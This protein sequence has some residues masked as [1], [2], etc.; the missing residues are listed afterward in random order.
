MSAV[1]ITYSSGTPY[2]GYFE[3]RTQLNVTFVTIPD[4]ITGSFKLRLRLGYS[5]DEN[6][7]SLNTFSD[8]RTA[9]YGA[10]FSEVL[11]PHIGERETS[12]CLCDGDGNVSVIGISNGL[13]SEKGDI[14]M[15]YVGF[16]PTALIGY[17]GGVLIF[18]KSKIV[19]E[20]MAG[21]SVG[22]IS[23]ETSVIKSDLGCDM[24]WSAVG[25]D[26]RIFFGNTE[27]GIFYLNKFG[28]SEKDGSCI[29][30]NAINDEL[31]SHTKSELENAVSVCTAGAYY[32]AVGDDVY[33]WHYDE[34]LPSSPSE[35]V[36]TREK[37]NWSRI[38][39]VAVGGYAG[40]SGEKVCF[41]EKDSGA[42]YVYDGGKFYDGDISSLF[43][44]KRLDFGSVHEKYLLS[45]VLSADISD[46]AEIKISFDGVGAKSSYTISAGNAD[47]TISYIIR[48]ERHKF[49][50]VSVKITSV[51][52]IT[53]SGIEFVYCMAGI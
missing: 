50:A 26:D 13:Y 25:F 33:V 52:P 36:K 38:D 30:S 40:T 37:Y 23:F 46:D 29:V 51:S 22:E 1:S 34:A 49:R 41:I 42:V 4:G 14:S 48:P 8:I 6:V 24:P 5:G 53:I 3:L 7:L 43:E 47:G 18:G 12:L 16:S 28:F 45:L 17:S 31:L 20:K 44:S 11:Y 19:L 9:L 2:S 27:N 10:S 21:Q 39:A 35:S 15:S 32:V